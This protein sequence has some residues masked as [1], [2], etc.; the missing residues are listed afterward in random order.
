MEG[1]LVDDLLDAGRSNGAEVLGHEIEM[2]LGKKLLVNILTLGQLPGLESVTLITA[3]VEG[4][5][6]LPSLNG[7]KVI[8]YRLLL[9]SG[10]GQEVLLDKFGK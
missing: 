1:E 6:K 7:E 2:K 10:S 3:P 4:P 8:G 9:N 5:S